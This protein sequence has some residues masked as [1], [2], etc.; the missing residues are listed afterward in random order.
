MSS[1]PPSKAPSS[2]QPVTKQNAAFPPANAP[3]VVAEKVVESRNLFLT[4]NDLIPTTGD[5]QNY[6]WNLGND[7]ITTRSPAQ[8]IR[9]TLL[10]FNMYKTWTSVNITNNTLVVKHLNGLYEAV[11]VDPQNYGSVYDLV[12]NFAENL[13]IM[14]LFMTL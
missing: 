9:L 11:S 10:N 6:T 7:A 12:D 13:A 1:N 5:G 2:N 3:I 8:Y 4:S 14:V